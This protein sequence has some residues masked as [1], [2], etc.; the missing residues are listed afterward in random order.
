MRT[1]TG[2]SPSDGRPVEVT[3]RDGVMEAIRPATAGGD[4]WLSPGFVDLQVNGYGGEDVNLDGLDP[5]AIISLTHKMIAGGVTTFLPTIITAPEEKIIANLRVIQQARML[6]GLVARSVPYVHVEGPH[7]SPIDGFRGAHAQEHIRPVSSAEFDRWQ[8][9]SGSLVG[10]VTVSPHFDHAEAYIAHLVSQNVHV[11][12]G[13]THASPE[14]IR[15]AINAG[16]RLSTHLG[17]GIPGMIDRHSN[18]IWPQLADDRLCATL[19]ADGHHLPADALKAM[20]RAKGMERVILVSDAVAVA[21]MPPGIYETP[22]GGRVEL[23]ARGRLSLHGTPYL[24][25]AAVPL[26]TGVARA[27]KMTGISIAE[28]VRAATQNPGRFAGGTGMMR[29]GMKAD[30][31]AFRIVEE[32]TNLQ[33]ERV[34][35]NGEEW[36]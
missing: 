26:K 11:A 34:I 20:I 23:D 33:I 36:S 27:M 12:L 22:I 17:N 7:L 19:I 30:L 13:H 3:V 29:V 15:N 10:M 35:V 5:A 14:Q 18:A 9:A 21:G 8:Q 16:A 25:G 1:I 31:V 24:A 32:G 28:S 2:V 4:L 6:S